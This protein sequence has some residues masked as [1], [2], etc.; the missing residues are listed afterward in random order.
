M[1]LTIALNELK[2]FRRN[3]VFVALVASMLAL[4]LAAAALSFQRMAT[5]ERERAAAQETD[6]EVFNNQGERNPHSAAHFSRYAFKPIPALA[7]FDPGITDYAGIALWMEAHYQNPAV[8]RRAEDLGDAGRFAD[9]SPA[10]ILQVAAPLFLFLVL[11]AA[12]AGER[13]QGT[14]RQ[15]LASGVST[16]KLA[17]GKLFG[18]LLGVLLIVAPALLIGLLVAGNSVGAT[19]PDPMLRVLGLVLAYS[20]FLL[21]MGALALGVSAVV[22]EKRT[23]LLALVGIWG[24]AFV[25]LPRMAATVALASHPLPSS[26][27][28][29]EALSDASRTFSRD[30]A[31]QAAMDADLLAEH[32]VGSTDDLPFNYGGYRLQYSEEYTHPLF[33]A[34]YADLDATYRNQ[35]R[36]IAR[37]SL[38]SPVVALDTLSAGLAGT[39][40]IHHDAFRSAAE[41]HRRALVK[42]LNED[43]QY[44]AGDAGFAYSADAALWQQ[45]EDFNHQPPAFASV[46]SHYRFSVAVLLAYALGAAAF[47]AWTLGR[48]RKGV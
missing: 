34:F 46:S 42:R 31:A 28:L 25:F 6:R 1:T 11:F 23:A 43:L 12:I 37:F 27:A 21:T 40:R 2:S 29:S 48:V 4:S 16:R 17:F 18:A 44:N 36:V 41:Q 14:L 15:T 45:V 38:L 20:V 3:G 5:F 47:A 33:E 26:T 22:R 24:A 9:L 39:D 35:E 10:W 30:E 13:E 32:G 7:S 8:F 19:L